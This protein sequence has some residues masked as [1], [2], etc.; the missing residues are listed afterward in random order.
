MKM[1]NSTKKDYSSMS[2][3]ALEHFV[4]L[5]EREGNEYKPKLARLGVCPPDWRRVALAPC[6][7]VV[8]RC[9]GC[10]CRPVHGDSEGV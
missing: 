1:V 2:M 8:W 7:H 10:P 4:H 3:L 5:A 9:A 6:L